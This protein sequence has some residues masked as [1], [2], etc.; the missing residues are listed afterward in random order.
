MSVVTQAEI[1]TAAVI[2]INK[3]VEAFTHTLSYVRLIDR[4]NRHKNHTDDHCVDYTH[5]L[6]CADS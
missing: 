6:L 5:Y 2:V 3:Y 1:G 4:H